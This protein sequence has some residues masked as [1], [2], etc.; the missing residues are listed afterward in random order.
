MD[1]VLETDGIK[2]EPVPRSSP[3]NMLADFPASVTE[4]LLAHA[5]PD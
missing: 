3:G 4:H 2:S 5:N 1:T